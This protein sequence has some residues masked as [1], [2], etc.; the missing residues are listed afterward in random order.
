VWCGAP[1]AVKT[2]RLGGAAAGGSVLSAGAVG[3][4]REELLKDFQRETAMLRALH[5]A[6]PFPVK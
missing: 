4:L 2:I 6:R 5:R 1:V 3:G